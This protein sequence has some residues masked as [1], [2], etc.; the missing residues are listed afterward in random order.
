MNKLVIANWKC[1]PTTLKEA[2]KLFKSIVKE[3]K[4]TKNTEVVIC[5]PAIYLLSLK[6]KNIKMGG[7]D[8]FWEERGAYTGEISPKMLKD[9]GCSYVILGHSERRKILDETDEVINKKIKAALAV[10]LTVVFCIGET[11]A[12]RMTG[13]TEQILENKLRAGLNGIINPQGVIIAYEP[14]WAI[15]NGNPCD[16]GSSRE[17]LEFLREKINTPIIYG[18]SVDSQCA[19]SYINE[20]GFDGLLVGAASLLPEEFGMIVKTIS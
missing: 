10:G 4:D 3:T 1:N 18:G 2:K 5:P 7:Q 20:A 13:Q 16:I 9:A 19:I 17:T 8:C 11:V 12:E 14:V 15:G 6:D